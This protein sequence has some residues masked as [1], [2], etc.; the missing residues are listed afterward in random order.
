M[1]DKRN[2]ISI[3]SPPYTYDEIIKDNLYRDAVVNYG[4]SGSEIRR[5][6]STHCY[7]KVDE[8]E[9]YLNVS[10]DR[11]PIYNIVMYIS[12]DF[13]T[14]TIGLKGS[15]SDIEIEYYYETIENDKIDLSDDTEFYF[16]SIDNT[17]RKI[18]IILN[19]DFDSDDA[20]D[21]KINID[22]PAGSISTITSMV[23]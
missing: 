13:Y 2:Y 22:F 18:T 6:D 3:L 1:I 16:E 15:G 21:G 10:I 8:S 7:V 14:N 4:A 17:L 19:Y 11:V 20:Y 23:F 5:Y 12:G 9:T